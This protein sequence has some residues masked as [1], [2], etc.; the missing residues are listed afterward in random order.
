MYV[1][2]ILVI[3]N[4]YIKF[5]RLVTTPSTTDNQNN[6]VYFSNT[7]TDRINSVCTLD[8]ACNVLHETL[9]VMFYMRRYM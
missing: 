5:A 8:V 2:L 4:A 3:D 7:C 1:N 6:I 9:H